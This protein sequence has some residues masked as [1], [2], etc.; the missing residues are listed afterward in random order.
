MTLPADSKG[1]TSFILLSRNKRDGP[2]NLSETMP[3]PPVRYET[4]DPDVRL[5]L[6][7]RDGDAAAFEALVTRYQTRL[8]SVLQHI[9]HGRESAEDMA[10]EVFMRV[11][12]SRKSYQPKAKFS[13]WLFTIANNVAL[14]A[15]RRRS[16]RKEVNVVAQSG[17]SQQ[18]NLENMAKEA[19]ALM[20]ARQLAQAEMA[21]VVRN[22][23][24]TLSE[25]QRM[26][27]L[28]SKF[29]HMCYADIATTMDLSVEA[30]KSLLFRARENLR[31]I[32]EPYVSEDQPP[33]AAKSNQHGEE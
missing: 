4:A 30:V 23:I 22:A 31:Q 11:F 29:E 26:A 28:L 25:R 32:L 18:P 21:E 24:E 13:T 3:V 2:L 17:E 27:L 8:I 33:S 19:S 10:Q 16:R 7:V 20:P 9:T 15:Q 12:R 1:G 5:M 14:N 6:R